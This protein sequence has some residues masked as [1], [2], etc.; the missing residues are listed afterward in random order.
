MLIRSNSVFS[1]SLVGGWWRHGKI[2]SR[3]TTCPRRAMETQLGFPVLET[4]CPGTWPSTRESNAP[5]RHRGTSWTQQRGLWFAL[6]VRNACLSLRCWWAFFVTEHNYWIQL[7][8]ST[9]CCRRLGRSRV[10]ELICVSVWL[11]LQR[12]LTQGLF[13]DLVDKTSEIERLLI[14]HFRCRFSQWWYTFRMFSEC[15]K[16]TM[17]KQMLDTTQHSTITLY[18]YV[19]LVPVFESIVTRFLIVMFNDYI[20]KK[21]TFFCPPLQKSGRLTYTCAMKWLLSKQNIS[22]IWRACRF[23][24]IHLKEQ[25]ALS[26]FFCAIVFHAIVSFA[27]SVEYIVRQDGVLLSISSYWS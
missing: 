13:A 5:S 19:H 1:I 12:L 25:I 26:F 16:N 18:S 7:D 23:I 15:W 9:H 27:Q 10:W 22:S 8:C 2:D 20:H 17:C 21:E 11:G 4:P 6:Q 24:Q 3:S 14:T